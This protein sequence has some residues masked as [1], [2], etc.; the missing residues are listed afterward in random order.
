MGAC[1]GRQQLVSHPA[2]LRPSK[3][4]MRCRLTHSDAWEGMYRRRELEVSGQSVLDP[5]ETIRKMYNKFITPQLNRRGAHVPLPSEVSPE[6]QAKAAAISAKEAK[7]AAMKSKEKEK[8][9][10]EKETKR[11]EEKEKKGIVVLECVFKQL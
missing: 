3:M 7:A 9:K 2:A 4:T 6:D 1:A 10:E 8:E 5:Q 11:E